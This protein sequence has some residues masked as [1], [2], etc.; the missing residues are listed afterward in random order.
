VG[1]HIVHVADYGNPAPGSFVPAMLAL[2]RTLQAAGDRC[3]FI[4]RDLPGAVWHDRAREELDSF[5]T[6][7]SRR[8][9]FDL[10]W[11]SKPDIVHVHFAGW[12]LPATL[13]AYA[14]GARV[15]W[16]LHSAMREGGGV[17]QSMRY[18]AKYRYFA[19]GVRTIVTV[20]EYLRRGVIGIGIPGERTA[21]IRNAIDTAH[22]HQPSSEQRAHARASLGIDDADRVLLFFGRDIDVKGADVLWRAL[23]RR[24]PFVLL[25]VGL[26]QRA[27][28]EFS[29]RVRTIAVPFT[30]DPAPLF[31][32]ADM[33]VMPSRREGA[34]YT[35]LEALCC[36]LPVV[37]S[38][39]APIAEIAAG[40]PGVTLVPNEPRALSAALSASPR[41][42]VNDTDGARRRFGLDRWVKEVASLY[43]A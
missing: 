6:A 36:G 18:A 16:H 12:S 21:L 37:A 24:S 10:V 1:Q 17:L 15:I 11:R 7:G 43:A 29:A 22:F 41:R 2:A 3:S 4:S 34:P 35:M 32:A 5:A 38:N 30:G 39:I 9:V 26:P 13:A 20:S 27:I 23:D 19:S 14:R 8:R 42:D 31:W 40:T 33:L 25:G 28:A